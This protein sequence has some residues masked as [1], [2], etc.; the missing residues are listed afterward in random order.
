MFTVF[1]KF[2]TVY[3]VVHQNIYYIYHANEEN[4]HIYMFNRKALEKN[5]PIRDGGLKSVLR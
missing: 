1:C 4:E 3:C 2:Y 5:A